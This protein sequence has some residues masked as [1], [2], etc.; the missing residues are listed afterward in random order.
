MP[1]C[2]Y[3][4]HTH[5]KKKL[6]RT[7]TKKSARLWSGFLGH[8]LYLSC[9]FSA[10]SCPTSF[11]SWS[12]LC[13]QKTIEKVGQYSLTIGFRISLEEKLVKV[14]T[15]QRVVVNQSCS[16]Q[17]RIQDVRSPILCRTLGSKIWCNPFTCYQYNTYICR[18][19]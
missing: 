11:S 2:T 15:V 9:S 4:T 7:C 3:N 16:T 14:I 6:Q 12:L 13:A 19:G 8:F 5:T 10:A 17:M 18:A 1:L